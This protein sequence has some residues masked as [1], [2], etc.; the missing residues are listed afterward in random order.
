[1]S[2]FEGFSWNLLAGESGSLEQGLFCGLG[3]WV[4]GFAEG[5]GWVSSSSCLQLHERNGRG[6]KWGCST[7]WDLED[8]H[9]ICACVLLPLRVLLS[10]EPWSYVFSWPFQNPFPSLLGAQG[11]HESLHWSVAL[12]SG[13]WVNSPGDTGR[14]RSV[15]LDC[16]PRSL[17]ATMLLAASIL[18]PHRMPSL[19][20]SA[21][22]CGA[23]ESVL[24]SLQA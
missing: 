4:S 24:A 5:S 8:R 7:V 17:L 16:H 19:V 3:N 11:G 20:S 21:S 1:M 2:P 10:L 14:K 18:P 13:F 9:L 22:S 23:C 15:R 12:F 6:C